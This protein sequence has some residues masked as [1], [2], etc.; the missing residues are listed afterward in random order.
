ML[1]CHH[2]GCPRRDKRDHIRLQ[3]VSLSYTGAQGHGRDAR[4]GA[5]DGHALGLQP[6]LVGRLQLPGPYNARY[7]AADTGEPSTVAF[8]ALPQPR[9]FLL[10]IR[11]RF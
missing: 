4:T 6:A 9:R 8:M 3:E 7:A 11:T 10:S 2:G 5:N 1:V